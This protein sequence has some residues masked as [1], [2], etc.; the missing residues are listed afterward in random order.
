MTRVITGGKMKKLLA[1]IIACVFTLI[2]FASCKSPSQ[3][4]SNGGNNGSNG[5]AG[6]TA[7]YTP[8]I[9][10]TDDD[11]NQTATLTVGV[12]AD[13]Y[14]TDLV[15]A[16]GAAFKQLFPNVTIEDTTRKI[17]PTFSIRAKPNRSASS[18]ATSTLISIRI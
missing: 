13:P 17:F 4:G 9:D 5:S 18:R 6:E 8:N 12:T 1:F 10:M 2:C 3:S 15:N 14:E 16:L 7:D 11:Y